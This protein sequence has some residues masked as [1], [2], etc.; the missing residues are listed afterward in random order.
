ME[1]ASSAR[2]RSRV[3]ELADGQCFRVRF[4]LDY[5]AKVSKVIAQMKYGDKPGIASILAPYLLVALDACLKEDA[6][7]VPVPMHP[8]KKRER[9]YNQSELLSSRLSRSSGVTSQNRLLV[10]TRDTAA[11]AALE[12]EA[13]AGNVAGSFAVRRRS[14]PAR[15]SVILVDDVLTTGSTLRACAEAIRGTCQ[16]EISACVV[17]SSV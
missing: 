2:P 12:K 9:G 17:A 15:R 14:V 10:K 8:A 3:V 4:A 6:V 13:R 5:T 16:G 11:Q 1:F 7:L